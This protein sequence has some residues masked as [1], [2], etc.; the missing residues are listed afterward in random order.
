MLGAPSPACRLEAS[1][2][3]PL[4]TFSCVAIVCAHSS[5]PPVLCIRSMIMQHA[6]R[7]IWARISTMY[8]KIGHPA[9]RVEKLQDSRLTMDG[10]AGAVAGAGGTGRTCVAAGVVREATL[11]KLA[12]VGT[13]P[14]RYHVPY[15]CTAAHR[16]RVRVERSP[17]GTPGHPATSRNP[18]QL[19]KSSRQP[20]ISI[21]TI[22][23]LARSLAR[24]KMVRR[25]AIY[26]TA[27]SRLH[28]SS[29]RSAAQP[30]SCCRNRCTETDSTGVATGLVCLSP[31]PSGITAS[32]NDLQARASVSYRVGGPRKRRHRPKV[33]VYDILWYSHDQRRRTS[34]NSSGHF[35]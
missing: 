28:F 22:D 2:A 29:K 1:L 14:H 4:H 13:Y 25:S 7:A 6:A 31:Y 8:H 16:W 32:I 27:Q 33:V 9:Y 17:S 24:A 12:S 3:R 15:T 35:L 18:A 20:A 23:L 5:V 21:H 19:L 10:R 34:A 11:I 30:S 26:N